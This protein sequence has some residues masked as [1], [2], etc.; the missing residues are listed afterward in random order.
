MMSLGEDSK[1]FFSSDDL[2]KYGL[3]SW[4]SRPEREIGTYFAK[5]KA[6]GVVNAVGEVPSELPGN[7]R[8]KVDL[9]RWNWGRWRS[10]VRGRLVP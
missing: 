4:F 1:E 6:N 9:L 3:D 8:R 5:L 7:N 10:I 2:R